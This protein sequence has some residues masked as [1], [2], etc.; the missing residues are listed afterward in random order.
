M[1][2]LQRCIERSWHRLVVELPLQILERA[3]EQRRTHREP[4]RSTIHQVRTME[5]TAPVDD[6]GRDHALRAAP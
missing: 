6:L 1:P 4:E 3:R 5:V 2:R